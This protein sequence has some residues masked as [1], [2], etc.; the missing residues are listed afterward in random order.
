MSTYMPDVGNSLK[1]LGFS[2]A[3]KEL[4]LGE[5]GNCLNFASKTSA[6]RQT[7]SETASK[8]SSAVWSVQTRRLPALSPPLV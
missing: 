8:H 6:C 1:M 4:L 7:S 2:L 5:T 3:S